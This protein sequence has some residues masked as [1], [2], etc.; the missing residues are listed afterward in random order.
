MDKE[1]EKWLLNLEPK[2]PRPGE[3]RESHTYPKDNS[4]HIVVFTCEQVLG[5]NLA[6]AV[7]KLEKSKE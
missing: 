2:N 4:E 6:C 7:I 1:F 3:F 5:G